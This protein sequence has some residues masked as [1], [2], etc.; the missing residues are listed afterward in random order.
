M[1]SGRSQSR[2]RADRVADHLTLAPAIHA[3]LDVALVT[4]KQIG[5]VILVNMNVPNPARIT[6]AVLEQLA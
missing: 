2:H 4:A 1:R 6:A 3:P 5:I